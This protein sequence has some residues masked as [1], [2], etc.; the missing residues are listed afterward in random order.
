LSAAAGEEQIEIE[1][2]YNLTAVTRLNMLAESSIFES[3]LLLLRLRTLITV[4]C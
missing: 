4:C 2:D 1:I 3:S